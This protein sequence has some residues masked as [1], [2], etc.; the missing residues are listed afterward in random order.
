MKTLF[1]DESGTLPDPKDK[2]V[3]VAAVGT[4]SPERIERI[5]KSVRK[6]GKFKKPTGEL[7]FYT[8]GE[9]TK[10]LF[11]QKIAEEDFDI[12]V[13][14]VEKLGRAVPDTP[15][16]FAILCGLLLNDVFAFCPKIRKIVFDRHF[17]KDKDIKKFNQILKQFLKKDLPEISHVDSKR[18]KK[19]NIADMI[20]GAVLAKE[21]GKNAHFYEMFKKKIVSESKI[22]WPEAKRRLFQK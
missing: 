16:H 5:M 11:F 7:K 2:V 8:V 12:F 18:N 17:H 20:A 14:T 3:I 19:V 1:I 9:K 21:T 10:K 13:L 4:H 22:N 6:R 15:E